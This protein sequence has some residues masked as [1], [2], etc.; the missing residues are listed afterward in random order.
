MDAN[1]L[2]TNLIADA[3]S[4]S[5]TIVV[6]R[7]TTDE[8]LKFLYPSF[9]PTLRAQILMRNPEPTTLSIERVNKIIKAKWRRLG[10]KL[11]PDGTLDSIL[12][13]SAGPIFDVEFVK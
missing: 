11:R 3:S 5:K 4:T 8:V 2:K 1:I 6:K 12:Q 10:V 9:S 13:P 7:G